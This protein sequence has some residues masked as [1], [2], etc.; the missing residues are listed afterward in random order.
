MSNRFFG[1][2]INNLRWLAISGLWLLTA[3][4]TPVDLQRLSPDPVLQQV[5]F[6]SPEIASTTFVEAVKNRNETAIQ[7]ILGQNYKDV[8]PLKEVDDNDIDRFLNAWQQQHTLQDQTPEQ[9]NLLVGEQQWPMPIPIVHN[10]TGWYFD[11]VKGAENMRVRRIGRHERAAIQSVLAYYD[12]QREYAE[13]DHNN[14]GVLEY[15]Q[16]LISSPGQ[17]DG[18]YWPSSGDDP[19]SPLGDL[20]A[21]QSVET[22]YHGYFYKILTGQGS[23]APN[24]AYS[25]L[26]GSQMRSG[27]ALLAWPAVYGETGVMSFMISHDGVVYEADLGEQTADKA[28]QIER[29]DPSPEWQKN[30][31]IDSH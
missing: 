23:H 28:K 10:D 2:P 3:C 1:L 15:A 26:I 27:F 7:Q 24:G 31:Q 11:I 17:K 8:L 22:A 5:I 18:L 14:D 29:F 25:Y 20:L 13:H 6:D 12:A 21:E 19:L 16:K 4:T 30:T 9:K